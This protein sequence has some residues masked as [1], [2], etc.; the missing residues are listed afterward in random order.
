MTWDAGDFAQSA[1]RAREEESVDPDTLQLI[2]AARGLQL[3]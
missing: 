2:G 3:P 1:A